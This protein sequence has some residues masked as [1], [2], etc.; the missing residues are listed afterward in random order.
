MFIGWLKN[1][2]RSVL[3]NILILDFISFIEIKIFFIYYNMFEL[4][5]IVVF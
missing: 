2:V 4:I 5:V 3:L 1:I